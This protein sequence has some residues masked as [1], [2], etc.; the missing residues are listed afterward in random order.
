M[1]E[2]LLSGI[3]GEE[4]E[5]SEIEGR[6]VPADVE[7]FAAAV[8]AR[9][10]GNDPAVAR[11][12]AEF[13]GEQTQL[14][15][16][17][18]EHIRS[19]HQA[20]LHYLQ[21]QAREVDIRRFGL[22][23][24]VGFQLFIALLAAAVLTGIAIMI[25]DA[26]TSR[27]VVVEPFEAPPAL[28]GRGVTGKAVAAGFLDELLRLQNATRT[29][30]QKR[31]LANAWTGDIKLE[32][33]ETGVSVGEL[34]RALKARFG[35]DLHIDGE[36]LQTEAGSLVL[37]VRGDAVEPKSFEGAGG[38]LQKL[39]KAAAEY[40]YAQSEPALWIVYLAN[41]NR[42]AEAIE[43]GRSAYA[44]A[45]KSDRPYLLNYWA[46]AV[47]S[48]GGSLTEALGLYRAAIKL[49][50]DYWIGYN[51]VLNTLW[52]LGD[53][54]G[55]WRAGEE[56]RKVAG[57]RPGRAPEEEYQNWDTITWNLLAWRDALVKD[58]DAHGGVGTANVS[59]GTAIA[60][61]EERLHDPAAA[62][63]ALA[64]TK[65]DERDPSI[66]A[67]SHFVRGRLAA[68]AGDT[69][70]AVVELEAFA[71]LAVSPAVYFNFPGYTCWVALAEE[72]AGHPDKADAV[73]KNGGTYVDCYRFR[74]DI[75]DGRKD[76]PAAQKAY[77]QAVALAPDLPAAYFSWADALVRHGDL[78][79][80]AEKFSAANK[81]GPHW[82][83]PLKGWGDLLLSQGRGKEALAKYNE[84]L[85]YA[86]NWNELKN[87]RAAAMTRPM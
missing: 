80:A 28:A 50:P 67:V 65:A 37:T 8:A 21:G 43:F 30:A 72:A 82:A 78:A 17:Q 61:I 31:S 22:R 18:R 1:A 16:I 34:A 54:E 68:R 48:T 62:Q 26:V 63:L 9:L 32:V 29:S 44:S 57:G 47:S 24:R 64:T 13:L 35:H 19:E 4:D 81:R 60:D 42:F 11:Q 71:A 66:V 39:S 2:G 83:D 49:K 27:S 77:A 7:A 14:V 5:K 12:T 74:G 46:N 36:L 69:T 58:A 76:W 10:S 20:R 87:A 6:E 53:E 45:D 56:L 79:G 3:I 15:R 86:P 23:L 40:V 41:T 52:A 75:L 51:N 59:A 25:N 38:D 55:A 73:L 85:K 33:P 70:D 84:A